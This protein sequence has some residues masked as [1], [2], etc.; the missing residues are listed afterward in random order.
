M[1]VELKS[2][3]TYADE[4]GLHPIMLDGSYDY[5]ELMTIRYEDVSEEFVNALSEEDLFNFNV[6][7]V[8]E[9]ELDVF[10][11]MTYYN[12]R[13]EATHPTASELLEWMFKE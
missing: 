1:N 6:M 7:K 2:V 10:T 13:G 4:E 5:S 11:E 12:D 9:N 8:Q 3:G